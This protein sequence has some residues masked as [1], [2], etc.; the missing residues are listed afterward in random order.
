MERLISVQDVALGSISRHVLC[1]DPSWGIPALQPDATSESS[2]LD[3]GEVEVRAIFFNLSKQRLRE[4][5][6]LFQLSFFSCSEVCCVI[7]AMGKSLLPLRRA[8]A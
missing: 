8:Q 2:S 1:P 7:R 6:K 3:E 4:K 5:A